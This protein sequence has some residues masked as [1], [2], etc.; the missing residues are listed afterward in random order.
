LFKI[1]YGVYNTRH[2]VC[3]LKPNLTEDFNGRSQ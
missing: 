2:T 1:Q 3:H